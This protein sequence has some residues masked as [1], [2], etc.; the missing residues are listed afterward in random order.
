LALLTSVVLSSTC[1]KGFDMIRSFQRIE[2]LYR[3]KRPGGHPSRLRFM[4]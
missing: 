2:I 4:V 3:A 1:T